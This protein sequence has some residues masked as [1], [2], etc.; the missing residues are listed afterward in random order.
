[1]VIETHVRFGGL[2]ITGLAGCAAQTGSNGH[3]HNK[4]AHLFEQS[5]QKWIHSVERAS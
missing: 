5:G 4:A 2:A 1:V 3:K